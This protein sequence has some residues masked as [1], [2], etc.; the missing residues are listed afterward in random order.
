M[1]LPLCDTFAAL[2]PPTATTATNSNHNSTVS[3]S[4][5]QWAVGAYGIAWA[6]LKPRCRLKLLHNG[7][8]ASLT[9]LLRVSL[10]P[11]QTAV[12]KAVS[13]GLQLRILHALLNLSV[14]PECRLPMCKSALKPLLTLATAGNS[15]SG[16][17]RTYT[18]NTTATATTIGVK[19]GSVHEHGFGRSSINSNGE[20]PAAVDGSYSMTSNADAGTD[21]V[22]NYSCSIADTT[23]ASSTTTTA[24]TSICNAEHGLHTHTD[25]TSHLSIQSPEDHITTAAELASGILCNLLA[26]PECRSVMFKEHMTRAS[27]AHSSA[28]KNKNSNKK[29]QQQQQQHAVKVS[30]DVS[31][32]CDATRGGVYVSKQEKLAQLRAQSAR[33]QRRLA[34][35]VSCLW[36]DAFAPATAIDSSNGVD[37]HADYQQQQQRVYTGVRRSAEAAAAAAA[38]AQATARSNSSHNAKQN[39]GVVRASTAPAG[40]RRHSTVNAISG[41]DHITNGYTANNLTSSSSSV[42]KGV[43][44]TAT[45]ALTTA[46]STNRAAVHTTTRRSLTARSGTGDLNSALPILRGSHRVGPSGLLGSTPI[47]SGKQLCYCY[48]SIHYLLLHH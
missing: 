17:T 14:E 36:E 46:A 15:S 3:T 18:A 10:V 21:A 29:K 9:K 48:T 16:T 2:L 20:T 5:E 39:S 40:G 45:A 1:A 22:M 28:I 8:L 47:Q 43:A 42:H 41:N 4:P 13:P 11:T 35:P 37:D 19:C 26:T 38:A 27:T 12:T 6:A 34:Q 44:K 30:D 31:S 33:T 25:V 32:V 23:T 7:A 24:T